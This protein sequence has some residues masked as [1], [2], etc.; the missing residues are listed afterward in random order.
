MP[1][2][3]HVSLGGLQQ[4]HEDPQGRGF[5]GAVGSQ[6]P[7]DLAALHGEVDAVDGDI[8]VPVTFRSPRTTSGVSAVAS[9]TLRSSR[10]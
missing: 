2:H 1:E 9:S 8:A 4:T 7:D 5:T 10:R 6:Q 3:P